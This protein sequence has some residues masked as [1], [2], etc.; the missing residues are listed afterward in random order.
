[1]LFRSGLSPALFNLTS[2]TNLSLS[3]NDFGLTILLNFGFEQLNNLL[4][5]DLSVTSFV[6]QVP[7]GISHLKNLHTLDLS[8][9]RGLYFSEPSFQMVVQNLSNLRNLYLD[10]VDMSRDG[11]NWSNF[12]A[13]F[14]P[15]LQ[16]LSL[17]SC[18][19]SGHIH[20]SFSILQ[21]P[22]SITLSQNSFSG[23]VPEFLADLSSLYI[24]D[25]FGDD[26]EGQFPTK[27][28]L[29]KMLTWID[30]SWNIRLSGHLPKFPVENSLEFLEI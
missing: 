29:L 12:L 7:T 25:L 26:F 5:L 10:E 21:S 11:K 27:I 20:S 17:H 8:Y 2:L 1:M 24:L 6:G 9:N 23:K 30:L 19:L 15:R 3:G 4:S 18:G 13:N 16:Y 22:E 28:C 14:V